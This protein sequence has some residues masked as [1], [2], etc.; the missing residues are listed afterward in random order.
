MYSDIRVIYLLQE[1]SVA[2]AN[3]EVIFLT[4]NS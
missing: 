4:G 3:G 2:E 1:I